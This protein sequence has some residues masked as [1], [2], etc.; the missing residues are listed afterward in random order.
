MLKTPA[1]RITSCFANAVRLSSVCTPIAR[2]LAKRMRDAVAEVQI[3]RLGGLDSRV[4]DALVVRYP[5]AAKLGMIPTP[6]WF[7][8]LMSRLRGICFRELI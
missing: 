1:V 8:E 5:L 3:V 6:I 2:V 4:A 7:P